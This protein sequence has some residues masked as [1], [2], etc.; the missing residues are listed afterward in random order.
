MIALELWPAFAILELVRVVD[1]SN[2]EYCLQ[3]VTL[4]IVATRALLL[5]SVC[6]LRSERTIPIL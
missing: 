4:P 6:S 3:V 5:A 2:N 1:S